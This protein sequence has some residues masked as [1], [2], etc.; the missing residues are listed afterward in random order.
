MQTKKLIGI[1]LVAALVGTVTAVSVSARDVIPEDEI[2]DYFSNHTIG[3]VGAMTSWGEQPD[4]AMADPDGDGVYVGVVKDLAAGEYEFKVRADSAWD[5]SW[6]EYEEEYERTFNSQTN[7]K[8]TVEDTTD[9]IV[10][11]DTNGEDHV[12]WPVK[13]YSTE[14]LEA[15]KYGLVGSMTEWGTDA[16]VPMYETAEG[17]Y[18]GTFKNLAAGEYEFKIRADSAWDESYGVY[19]ADYDRTNNSQTNCKVALADTADIVVEFDA[20]GEDNIVWPISYTVVGADGKVAE[21]VYAGKEKTTEESS[22]LESS[23]PEE[24]KPE[25]SKPEESTPESSEPEVSVP[26]YYET[27][28]GDY[29]YFDNSQTKWSKVCVYW[30]NSEGGST[31]NIKG[32]VYTYYDEKENPDG[33]KWP[34]YEMKQIPGTDIYQF[35]V[36][37]GAT[38]LIFNDGIPDEDVHAGTT[39]YQTAD[40]KLEGDVSGKIYTIDTTVDPVPGRGIE[41]TKFKYGEGAWTAYTG[42]FIS[43]EI[44]T[45]VTSNP[46]QSSTPA[47]SSDN[48][49]DNNSNN[50]GNNGSANNNNSGNNSGTPST[51]DTSMT[52]VFVVVAAAALGVVVLASKKKSVKE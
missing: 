14:A 8:I 12:V 3:I 20:T 36:P 25:E 37:K 30:W 22:E 7:C 40:L 45:P 50:N 43:E 35:L 38:H 17:R 5:D 52:I 16:D 27:Q 31:Y 23:E 29:I 1:A 41:K 24:S 46:E 33:L 42:E 9:L 15:S 48:S 18:V 10:T 11:L 32:E 34:G 28:V 2:A 39:A 44:G 13:Y 6:G 49:T 47:E 4:V 26:D 21:T 19:E 51:G